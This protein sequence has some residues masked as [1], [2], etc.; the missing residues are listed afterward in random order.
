MPLDTLPPLLYNSHNQPI[1]IGASAKWFE[2][3]DKFD[4]LTEMGLQLEYTPDMNNLEALPV[5]LEPY[6]VRE[7]TVRHHAF[8]PGLELGDADSDLSD[9]SYKRHIKM[10][11]LLAGC[12][13]QIVTVHIGLDPSIRLCPQKAVGNL[14][15][16][17][18]E[19]TKLGITL[20]LENLRRGPTSNPH[21]VLDWATRSGSAIT[22]DIG[23]VLCSDHTRNGGPGIIEVIEMFSSRLAEVHF[24]EN[25]TDR[26]YP[27]ADMTVLGPI[28]DAL[29]TT[30]CDWWT[31][32]L[33]SVAEIETTCRLLREYLKMKNGPTGGCD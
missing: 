25:E 24:Y 15:N 30:S 33:G 19:A 16:L 11:Q 32:E 6:L 17:V 7:V 12:G 3:P 28:V 4:A 22:L 27:P 13:E 29:Q 5:H 9:A 10:L 23:H 20:S 18:E 31:I 2:F 8:F 14:S 1:R 26:H 21:L